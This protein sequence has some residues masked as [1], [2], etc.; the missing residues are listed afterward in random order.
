MY[1]EANSSATFRNSL[2]GARDVY[3]L[4]TIVM[5][6]AAF[7]SSLALVIYN[8]VA[9]TVV[10]TCEKLNAQLKKDAEADELDKVE[11]LSEYRNQNRELLDLANFGFSKFGGLVTLTFIAGFLTHV[12]SAFVTRS[13]MEDILMLTKIHTFIF[14]ILGECLFL[15]YHES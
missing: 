11:I 3:R 2:F 12:L 1:G 5:V 4:D 14:M 6:W 15:N 9:N 8:L 10:V 7:I 13:F